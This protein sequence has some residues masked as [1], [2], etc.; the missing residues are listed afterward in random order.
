MRIYLRCDVSI[1]IYP[2]RSAR[3]DLSVMIYRTPR[4]PTKLETTGPLD[5]W[6]IIRD[7]A[8]SRCM[9]QSLIKYRRALATDRFINPMAAV[10]LVGNKIKSSFDK[11][12]ND[13]I[14]LITV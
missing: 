7:H 8:K 2:I 12:Y 13:C 1:M 5:H 11:S 3:H 10:N 6:R 9:D 4:V 14:C